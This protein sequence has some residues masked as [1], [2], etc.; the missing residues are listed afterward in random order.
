MRVRVLDE[1]EDGNRRWRVVA[2]DEREYAL[3]E[4]WTPADRHLPRTF[5]QTP[6]QREE[7]WD[8]YPA[9]CRYAVVERRAGPGHDD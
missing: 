2:L 4:R 6:L 9:E 3:Q 8:R 5:R 1:G 7:V